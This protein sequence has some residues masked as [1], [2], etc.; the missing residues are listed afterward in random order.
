MC[1]PAEAERGGRH[2]AWSGS[3]SQVTECGGA[4]R[5]EGIPIMVR[6]VGVF[7]H[8]RTGSHP[9]AGQGSKIP[10]GERAV[11]DSDNARGSQSLRA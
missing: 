5:A 2:R 8:R 4:N 6:R 1:L 7:S 9:P 10:A 11:G 3:V